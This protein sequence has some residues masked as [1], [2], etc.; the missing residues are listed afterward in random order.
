MKR[1]LVYSLSVVL[2]FSFAVSS[3]KKLNPV[4]PQPAQAGVGPQVKIVELKFGQP[5][6][7]GSD[8]SKTLPSLVK[9]RGISEQYA[10]G[11][12]YLLTHRGDYE[13]LFQKENQKAVDQPMINETWR[14]CTIFSTKSENSVLMGRNWDNQNV[15]SIIVS[16]YQPPRGYSSISFT[17]AIDM[18]FPLN[19]DLESMR[20]TPLGS[21]L[22]L[23]PFYAY[24]GLNEHG[25]CAAVTGIDHVKVGPKQ[26][27]ELVFVAF[28]VRKI[29]D[30]TKSVDEAVSLAE[31]YV[32]FDIDKNSLDCHFYVADAS[33]RSVILEYSGNEWQT[34]YPERSWQVMTNNVIAGVPEAKLREKCRR[35][36][37]ISETLEKTKGKVDWQSG[38]QMLRDAAQSGTTWSVVY[39]PTSKDV[40]FSVYQSWDK[41]Y[42]LVGPSSGDRRL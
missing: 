10:T 18:G 4:P 38:M 26:G 20:S 41:I 40:Y 6:A 5:P 21:R 32:P 34:I 3:D 1:L 13:E 7:P 30:Q 14:Y 36:R 28:L 25:V 23:A 33:G 17:R 31:R 16:L 2:V 37:S 8:V 42:H 15:G 19:V 35:Y 24:D 29:L 27:K 22:L 11:G 9:V 12:L 39:S